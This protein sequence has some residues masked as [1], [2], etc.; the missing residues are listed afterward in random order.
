MTDR[1]VGRVAKAHGI[2]GE[3]AVD[4]FTSVPEARFAPGVRLV[5]VDGSR[6]LTV[7]AARPHQGRLLVVFEGVGDRSAAEALHGILLAGIDDIDAPDGEV[8]ASDLEGFAV[9]VDGDQAGVVEEVMEGAAQDLL[10]V[11]RPDDTVALV[12]LAADF[13]IAID[14]DARTITLTLPPGLL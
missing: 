14:R 7:A 9:V 6:S 4:V 8:W 11:R 2:R 13:V 12:P 1:V 5:E 10:A 3:V